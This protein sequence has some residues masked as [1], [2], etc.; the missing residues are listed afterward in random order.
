MIYNVLDSSQKSPSRP[1]QDSA[2]PPAVEQGGGFYAKRGKRYLDIT[3]A[4]ILLVVF[5][6]II[7]VISLLQLTQAGGA[8]FTHT[9]IGQFGEEFGCLKFRTMAADADKRLE[10]L[11][12]S[13]V[14]AR[15]E[16]R[17]TQKLTDDPRVT[18]LGNVLRRSSMD[19]L[20]QLLNV[21]RGEMSLVGP[22]PVTASELSK[23]GEACQ[24]YL[25]MRPGLTGKWQVSGRND[26]TYDER[27]QLDQ[28]YARNFGLVGD[29]AILAQ[30][31]GVVLGA[32]G[33]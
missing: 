27:V 17:E 12:A 5:S 15:Q 7:L 30:T 6:P 2:T 33:R 16:W 19:E 20:P 32:T 31:I 4:I 1:S 18:G 28:T 3:G 8:L 26:V 24:S 10:K 13:D 11:L 21:L 29:L 9:R 23:Y 25:A 14:E 22:R